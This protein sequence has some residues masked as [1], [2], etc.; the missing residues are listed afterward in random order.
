[1]ERKVDS[2]KVIK[3]AKILLDKFAKTLEKVESESDKISF[4]DRDEFMRPEEKGEKSPEGYKKRFLENAPK[5][6]DNF[7]IAEKGGWK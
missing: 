2:E 6:D 3:D 5:H 7:V 4:I 1:M